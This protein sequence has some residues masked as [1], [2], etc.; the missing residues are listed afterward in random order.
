MPERV[1][2]LSRESE[3]DLLRQLVEDL[4]ENFGIPLSENLDFSRGT[5][6]CGGG[7]SSKY[8]LIGRVADPHSFHP[9]PAFYVEYGTGSNP[10]PGL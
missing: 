1:H 6:A 3:K 9:D 8:M 10:D 7:K 5:A 2:P 4:R